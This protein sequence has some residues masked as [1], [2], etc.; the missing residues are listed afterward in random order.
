[1]SNPLAGQ[2]AGEAVD[3]RL[4]VKLLK[5]DQV[6]RQQSKEAL[7]QLAEKA[8]RA[9]ERA[10]P[11]TNAKTLGKRERPALSAAAHLARRLSI[12]RQNEL[13]A[14]LP[15]EVADELAHEMFSFETL[16]A[17]PPIA[18]EQVLRS[19]PPRT[20]ATALVGVPDE[21]YAFVNRHVSKRAQEM[22]AEE[23]DS[24]RVSAKLTI[25]DRQ[26]ARREVADAIR[27]VAY[28][29]GSVG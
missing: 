21:Y 27:G 23:I 24:V 20:L 18:A 2:E 8:A 6:H 14:R 13:L 11:S 9:V 17:L 25:R 22:L 29:S 19:V 26:T 4:I 7:Q 10:I 28:R 1:M 16:T 12:E 5:I 3:P 15:A